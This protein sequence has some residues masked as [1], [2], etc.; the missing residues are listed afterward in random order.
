MR[1]HAPSTHYCRRPSYA[2]NQDQTTS[3]THHAK[4][5]ARTLHWAGQSPLTK[6]STLA[7]A[8]FGSN[9]LVLEAG[10][11]CRPVQVGAG[12]SKT[13]HSF[14]KWVQMPN[15]RHTRVL[16]NPWRSELAERRRH[17]R[18]Q[19]ENIFLRFLASWSKQSR[20]RALVKVHGSPHLQSRMPSLH[21]DCFARVT[22]QRQPEA[23]RPHVE[24]LSSDD[25][26]ATLSMPL[27]VAVTSLTLTEA[28]RESEMQQVD[29]LTGS[30][31]TKSIR[32]LS[33]SIY[34]RYFEFVAVIIMILL[35][36]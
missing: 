31:G 13:K 11:R 6:L 30:G 16:F 7:A 25:N 1:K 17:D 2:R 21:R 32:T 5:G 15:Y 24:H 9:A 23:S 22:G 12:Q 34:V 26:L 20:V 18:T 4:N 3:N 10:L 27:G 36:I 19:K 28:Q 29:R 8:H 14:R 33:C 35:R